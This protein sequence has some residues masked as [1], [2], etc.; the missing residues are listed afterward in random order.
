MTAQVGTKLRSDARDNR[1]RI[2]AVARLAFAAE[3][4]EVPIREIARRAGLGVAT[5]YRHFQTKDE[6]LA[7]A[8]AE[9]MVLCSAVVAEGLAAEDPWQ[10][11]SLVVSKLMEVHALDRGFARA[12]MSQLPQALDFA[13]ERDRTLRQLLELVDRAKRAGALREDFVLEDIS[14]ALM[15]NEGIR[16]EAPELRVAASRRFAALMLQSFQANPTA[17]PLPPAVRLPLTSP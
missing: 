12:F 7:A 5:V 17:A 14:L 4:I 2:L 9:Q 1:A 11:F 16:A 13:A 8:F 15:A 6:L 3:G 10:G